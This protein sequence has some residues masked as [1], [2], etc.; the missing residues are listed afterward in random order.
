MALD[1]ALMESVRA[2]APPVL[3]FYRWRPACLSFGR[4]QPAVGRYDREEIARRGL[5]VV[6]RP[7]GGR[8]VVHARELTYAVI[9]PERALGTLRQTYARINRALL[10]GVRGLGVPAVL[11]PRSTQRAPVPSTSPCFRDPTEGEVVVGGRKLI[12]SAQYR[13]RGV[14]L[15][16][17][18]LLL[19]DD[20]ALLAGLQR[21]GAPAQ[22][23]EPP[24]VLE[25]H[26]HPLPG[27]AELTGA[28]VEGWRR[29]VCASLES[30]E[31]RSAEID[32]AEQLR[33]GHLDMEWIWRR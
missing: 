6:R 5:D 20:Q 31:P 4:N 13:Q 14:L 33:Q 16:H 23:A 2:G 18:S 29:E 12:G 26:C 22:P 10:A 11:Q 3:R 8:A 25:E 9:V 19:A 27:W 28:L 7:T 24:A 17:G 15:Q 32:R 30:E 21:S 1:E